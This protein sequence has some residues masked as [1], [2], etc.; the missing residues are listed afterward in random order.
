M[1]S[2]TS[3]SDR[4]ATKTTTRYACATSA[5]A[6]ALL[7]AWAAGQFH[8]AYVPFIM[9][10]PALVFSALYCGI[11][12]SVVVTVLSVIGARYWF[13]A[14]TH[15]LRLRSMSDLVGLLGCVLATGIIVAMGETHRRNS[16]ALRNAQ[17]ELDERVKERTEE[18]DVA[19]RS[20]RQ[21]TSR[22]LQLQ[23]DER[24]RFARELHDSVGQMLAALSMNLFSV[25]SDIDR[26]IKTASILTDSEALVQEMSKEIR[27][28][29]HLLHPPLLDEAG[30]LS[31]IRWYTEGF[32]Q[33]SKIEVD[34]DI[35]EDFG[36]LP[37]DLETCIFRVVQEYLTN[38]HRHSESPVAV[39][40]IVRADGQ[41]RVE[42]GDSGKGIPKEKQEELASTGTP[43]VGI[44]GMR[45][46]LR[47]LGGSLEINSN[48]HGTL[49]VFQ[50]PVTTASAASA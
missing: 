41:V 43:G 30:L 26:V 4:I 2:N 32:A 12:P 50:L 44:R 35:S 18:L 36:R 23:D 22:V 8:N 1:R 24:R 37:R 6:L 28:I 14:P 33:R 38:I 27:T 40:R 29:S 3:L 45:E 34:L 42:V 20:L 19:N 5:A 17:R 31:A 21:L 47:Q 46:R 11:G 48:G 39:I 13:I 49:V 7:A 9:L 15:S 10:F 25:R 16:E